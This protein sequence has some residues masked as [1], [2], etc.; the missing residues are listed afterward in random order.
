M[1]KLIFRPLTILLFLAAVNTQA[2]PII[3]TD[4]FS[5][6]DKKAIL[7]TT[8][9]LT[10][11]DFGVTKATSFNQVMNNL[12]TT[13]QGWRL[14]TETEVRN[15][16]STLFP[17]SNN[18][19][20]YEI[21]SLWGA[22]I[23]PSDNLPYLCWGYFIDDNGYLGHGSILETGTGINGYGAKKYYQDGSIVNHVAQ[24]NGKKYDGSSFPLFNYGTG[25]ISTLLVKDASVTSVNVPEPSALI[26]MTLG[27]L[28]LFLGRRRKAK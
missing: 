21:F 6:G 3:D 5:E 13:Y 15:L 17:T 25:E 12:N 7:D 16:W 8:T 1:F 22:N 27:C 28:A 18:G 4:A 26:L 14:P 11:L 20:P 19:D 2:L 23:A 10:W 24:G 9:N